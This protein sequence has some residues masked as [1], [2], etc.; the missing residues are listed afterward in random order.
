M[1]LLKKIFSILV[2][3][4]FSINAALFINDDA[5]WPVLRFSYLGLE[6]LSFKECQIVD[7]KLLEYQQFLIEVEDKGN[8]SFYSVIEFPDDCSDTIIVIKDGG[9][10]FYSAKE[11]GI[12]AT[13]ENKDIIICKIKEID[14]TVLPKNIEPDE[15]ESSCISCKCPELSCD[16][17]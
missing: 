7:N 15:A 11:L 14:K 10:K 16:L 8:L 1:K 17:I 2:C 13:I 12:P 5:N 6:K 4:Q 9:Y 3:L